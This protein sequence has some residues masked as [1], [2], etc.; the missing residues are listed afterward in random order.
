MKKL[1]ITIILFGLS[2]NVVAAAE[3]TGYISSS[4]YQNKFYD[5]IKIMKT[6]Q[7]TI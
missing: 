7:I 1:L 2:V 3:D 6:H 5:F 4:E